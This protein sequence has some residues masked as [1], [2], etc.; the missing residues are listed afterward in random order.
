[1]SSWVERYRDGQCRQVWTEMTSLG[2]DL[3]TDADAFEAA[4]AVTRETM[5][6]ARHN[7]E[8]L[9]EQLPQHGFEFEAVPLVPPPADIGS[10][11]DALDSE[12]GVLPMAL[13]GWFEEVGNVNLN[14]RHPAWSFAY[15]DPLVVEAPVDFIRSEFEAWSHDLGTEWARGTIFEVPLAPDYLHKANVSGGGPYALAVPNPG[16]DGLLLWE[17]HQTTFVNYLRIAFQMGGMPGWVREPQ[18]L[19]E[20][21]L[22]AEQAPRWLVELG[23]GLL[24]I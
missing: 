7:V 24:P 17:P 3:R 18:L 22:P 8:R 11:L 6:R 1:M 15:P 14:G 5:L 13:R 9:I 12:V 20:W 23:E 21:A 10:Q 19:E 16:A 2:T 4:R